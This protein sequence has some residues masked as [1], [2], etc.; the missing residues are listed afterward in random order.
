MRTDRLAG[1]MRNAYVNTGRVFHTPFP[2]P[3][4]KNKPSFI[5]RAVLLKRGGE[6]NGSVGW[7]N[8][9]GFIHPGLS[10]KSGLISP[11]E[12]LFDAQLRLPVPEIAGF[13]KRREA[14]LCQRRRF[15]RRDDGLILTGG[16]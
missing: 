14:N 8:L 2:R 5:S 12:A 1:D 16:D 13:G 6:R 4:E 3:M 15:A 9:G 10:P 11:C 7:I